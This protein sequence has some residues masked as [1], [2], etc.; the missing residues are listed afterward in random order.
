ML[1]SYGRQEDGDTEAA[2][3][4]AQQLA[5]HFCDCSDP[6]WVW[7]DCNYVFALI[8]HDL[9][10]ARVTEMDGED[11]TQAKV[12]ELLAK[13][14]KELPRQYLHVP[15]SITVLIDNAA[16]NFAHWQRRLAEL[17]KYKVWVD[18]QERLCLRHA[19]QASQDL[20]QNDCDSAHA[21]YVYVG[22][23]PTR[24]GNGRENKSEA[25]CQMFWH[26]RRNGRLIKHESEARFTLGLSIGS[27]DFCQ[28]LT[29]I[30]D[31]FGGV[32]PLN[33]TKTDFAFAESAHGTVH[34]QNLNAWV[35]AV[36]KVYWTFFRNRYDKKGILG[37][38]VAA[39]QM[40]AAQLITE[41]NDSQP[42]F[43]DC[44]FNTLG[45]ITW[46]WAPRRGLYSKGS[47]FSLTRLLGEDTKLLLREPGT[48]GVGQFVVE[49]QPRARKKRKVTNKRAVV[50]DDVDAT[51]ITNLRSELD[52]LRCENEGLTK[53]YQEA[54]EELKRLREKREKDKRR[55]QTN[56]REIG[57]LQQQVHQLTQAVAARTTVEDIGVHRTNG[58]DSDSSSVE[59]VG[60]SPAPPR[61]KR[62][63][64]V[65]KE[66][67]QTQLEDSMTLDI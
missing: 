44:K 35:G 26:S 48:G 25:S 50:D 3:H 22:F 15:N 43:R 42:S 38:A 40:D 67:M 17:T 21:V 24:V 39:I 11:G 4:G 51:V 60:V 61:S 9:V 41:E 28:G 18:K 63:V 16:V 56:Q 7:G 20:Y 49:D 46:H 62:L 53:K 6:K 64:A 5:S 37:Q 14:K 59:F 57:I 29:V 13:V 33:P 30:V 2:D 32:L 66:K 45:P 1:A 55:R 54:R 10:H 34:R 47:S 23:D 31:D 12:T 36:T 8:V 27:T 58:E 52:V 65:K 19:E